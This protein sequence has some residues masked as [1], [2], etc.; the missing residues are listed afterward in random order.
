MKKILAYISKLPLWGLGGYVLKNWRTSL[1]GMLVMLAIL[2]WFFKQLT[3][4]DF[5]KILGFCSAVGLFAQIDPK[6]K[7]PPT[8]TNHG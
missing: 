7:N 1:L 2:L 8:P 6:F 5:L 3:T 4:D